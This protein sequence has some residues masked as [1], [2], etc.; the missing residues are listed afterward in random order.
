MAKKKTS[1]IWIG[2]FVIIG[3]IIGVG[4]TVW[5]SASKF[6]EG[7][8]SYVTYFDESVQGLHPDS[9]VKLR[10]VHIGRVERIG[11]EPTSAMVEV[12]MKLNVNESLRGDVCA[13]LKLAGL[14]GI[15]FIDLDRKREG[16]ILDAPPPGSN[17]PYPLIPS[18]P[19]KTKQV[20]NSLESATVHL[21]R[22]FRHTDRLLAGG[23]VDQVLSGTKDTIAEARSTLKGIRTELD[24]LQLKETSGQAQ[25]ILEGLEK[26]S[27]RISADLKVTTDNLRQVS[28]NLEV[29]VDRIQGDPSEI[30]FSSA[31]VPRPSRESAP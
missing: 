13:E 11:V 27:R 6:F 18:R 5:L 7:G 22:T 25:R 3:S 2:L 31:P 21:D 12:V 28:E 8:K 29:L 14:T 10:G 19:S 20:L 30:L 17:P 23:S 26:D 24:G 16:E 9:S 1:K 15:V 4:S